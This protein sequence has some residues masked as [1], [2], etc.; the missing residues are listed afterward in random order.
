L[1]NHAIQANRTALQPSHASLPKRAAKT[2]APISRTDYVKPDKTKVRAVA[3]C[4]D[5]AHRLIAKQSNQKTFRI[6][7]ME[8]HG[9]MEARVP[10]L[11]CGPVNTDLKLGA[12][13]HAY[14]KRRCF[15]DH[16]RKSDET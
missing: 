11:S 5:H 8:T 2:L 6:G 12:I 14:M 16:T 1:R 7:S 13:H 4:R 10:A 15:H 9:I 3:N